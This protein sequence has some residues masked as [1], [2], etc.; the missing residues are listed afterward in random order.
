MAMISLLRLEI[1]RIGS[2]LERKHIR[3]TLRALQAQ[4]I[5]AAWYIL[6]DSNSNT[7]PIGKL[8]ATLIVQATTL[9]LLGSALLDSLNLALNA[10]VAEKH[11]GCTVYIKSSR[12][13]LDGATYLSTCGI[14]VSHG[15]L[16]RI[17]RS[18][19]K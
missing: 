12:L 7:N 2:N 1:V 13:N 18:G 4:V 3:H 11:L 9:S 15:Q 5:N 17:E 8:W 6:V 19:E 14:E 16:L 10:R